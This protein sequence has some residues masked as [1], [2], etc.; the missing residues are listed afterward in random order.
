LRAGKLR[1]K[2]LLVAFYNRKSFLKIVYRRNDQMG[3][4]GELYVIDESKISKWLKE[5]KE[6]G[7]DEFLNA[8][9]TEFK[10][11]EGE[12]VR[13]SVDDLV[14]DLVRH[15]E[16]YSA[17]EK[18]DGEAML[19]DLVDLS[20][21][22]FFDLYPFKSF[23][24][25]NIIGFLIEQNRKLV[26]EVEDLIEQGIKPAHPVEEPFEKKK[27]VVV[28]EK[29]FET[30]EAFEI[31]VNN[32]FDG[33]KSHIDSELLESEGKEAIGLLRGLEIN[34]ELVRKFEPANKYTAPD[35]LVKDYSRA[36]D[37]FIKALETAIEKK[38]GIILIA[39]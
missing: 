1:L 29:F 4:V 18:Y 5:I 6:K 22:D 10:T 25:D 35:Q 28:L 9:K 30:K 2:L 32:D 21:A 26:Q 15:H 34:E 19:E 12:G 11:A 13:D 39:R 20:G 14:E 17:G 24:Y 37:Q 33:I 16:G 36:R 31:T 23:E 27:G 38:H 8:H 3:S 7:I